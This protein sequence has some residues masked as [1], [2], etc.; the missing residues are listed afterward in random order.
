VCN[1][2]GNGDRVRSTLRYLSYMRWILDEWIPASAE[3]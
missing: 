1:E 2:G 3:W